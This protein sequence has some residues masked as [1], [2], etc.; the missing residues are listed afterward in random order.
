[1]RHRRRGT[2]VA[3]AAAVGGLAL[4]G[5]YEAAGQEAVPPTIPDEVVLRM[6]E[7]GLKNIH[8]AACDGFNS[9][10]PTTPEELEF[11]PI[12]LDQARTALLTGT[13]T[14]L[15][16]WCGLDGDRRSVLPM[17]R[18]LRKVLRFN[19][20]QVALMAIIHGIQQSAITDRLKAKG[21]CD[22]E[23]RAKLDAQ[24]PK[25]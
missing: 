1:M 6:L 22:A 23:T 2:G 12:T 11:P 18:H 24:L 19:N 3:L 15:A 20:R 4:M 9:C 14:A 21:P 7:L 10:A 17:T 13:R 8:R 16:N 5:A 25:S